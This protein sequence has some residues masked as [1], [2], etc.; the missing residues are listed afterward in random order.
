MIL[1][2]PEEPGDAGSIAQTIEAAFGSSAEA[3]LVAVLREAGALC[4]SLVA[5]ADGAIVG[6]VALSPVAVGGI[7][8]GNR[9]LGLAPL[10]VR[11]EWQRRGIGSGL[12]RATLA[13]AASR[14]AEL[15][16]VLGSPTYYGRLGFEPAA[17][18]GWRCIYDVPPAA[19]QV[20]PLVKP[21]NRSPPGTVTTTPRSLRC[22]G[23]VRGTRLCAARPRRL[24]CGQAFGIDAGGAAGTHEA[25]QS[26]R[27]RR[28]PADPANGLAGL[29][30]FQQGQ[31]LDD[32]RPYR[33]Y[34]PV[35]AVPVPDLPRGPGRISRS[36]SGCRQLGG[37]WSRAAAPRC[38]LRAQARDRPGA[39]GPAC[40]TDDLRHPGD[41]VG[42]V[43]G[44]RG[45]APCAQP[46]LRRGRPA[47]FL[48]H[49]A[50]EPDA[51]H[52]GGHCRDHRHGAAGG[53][54]AGAGGDPGHAAPSRGRCRP[55]RLS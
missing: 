21:A 5:L 25:S 6:H 14:Q 9:W 27:R 55:R 52:P 38:R 42:L 24:G 35:R 26:A 43:L 39:P 40:G 48:A 11:P 13:M 51:H 3:Q 10:A 53:D 41:A 32:R 16:F 8:G 47:G 54:P 30:Q 44:P 34:G 33:L 50:G 31:W 36:G 46:R 28:V 29:L 23:G 22:D 45:A 4:W 7:S 19:F 12:V 2:R 37:A 20:R 15:V 17:P 1:L 18:L 49:P